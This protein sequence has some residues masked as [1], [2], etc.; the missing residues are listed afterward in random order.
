M[1]R[2][3]E[4]GRFT[5]DDD[6]RFRRGYRDDDDF[7]G[8][9]SWSRGRQDDDDERYGRWGSQRGYRDDD[10]Y[11][12]RSGPKGRCKDISISRDALGHQ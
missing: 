7:E 2:R 9:M 8:R 5:L 10:E 6:T 11:G 4:Y 3:D 12:R 1:P